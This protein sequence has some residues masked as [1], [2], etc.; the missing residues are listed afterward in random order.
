MQ[1][2]KPKKFPSKLKIILTPTGEE[3]I[4]TKVNE[5]ESHKEVA[6]TTDPDLI[7]QPYSNQLDTLSQ[8]ETGYLKNET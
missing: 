1:C 3:Q 4:E 5:P 8:N 2:Q 7:N 6:K